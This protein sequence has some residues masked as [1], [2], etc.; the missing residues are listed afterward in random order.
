MITYNNRAHHPGTKH[1][2]GEIAAVIAA[3]NKIPTFWP[4][5]IKSDSKY[6]I[7]DAGWIGIK[8]AALFRKAAY[9][10]KKRTAT[11]SFQWVK[12]HEGVQGNEES[13]KLAK[14]GAEKATP[15][16]L[17]LDIPM[18]YNL[19]GAKLAS[20]SQSIVYAG[21]RARAPPHQRP[22]TEKNLQ[23]AREAILRFNGTPELDGTIWK[24]MR[25]RALKPRIQQFLFKVTHGMFMIGDFWENIPDL[26]HRKW[27]SACHETE[28][29]EHILTA[30]SAEPVGLIWD[31]ARRT[32]PHPNNTWP[33][34]DFGTVIGCGS[35]TITT[36]GDH[37]RHNQPEQIRESLAGPNRLLHIL[38][39]ESAYLIWVLRCERAIQMKTHSAQEIKN[40]WLRAINIRLTNDKI[41]TS[42]I[43]R[44]NTTLQ[45]AVSTWK[46]VLDREWELPPNWI[47]HREVL[48]G[49]GARN[50][51][52]GDENVH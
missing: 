46:A 38:I 30:C 36:M 52:S 45:L 47:T 8:N 11:T 48:V 5:L 4:I 50:I 9:L 29:M 24:N 34:I 16:D 1:N 44:K 42:K 14:A 12:G 41:T 28:T 33:Q 17:P 37:C 39:S 13:D 3:V 26:D 22:T 35:L 23:Q 15:D 27:C 20:L 10:L 32:W 19:Q 25:K 31:L 43:K 51:R 18:E 40:R 2:I 6:V 21:I 49:R 7:E